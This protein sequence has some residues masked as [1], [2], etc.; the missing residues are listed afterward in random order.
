MKNRIKVFGMAAA[1]FLPFAI[2]SAVA[3]HQLDKNAR[4]DIER[5]V[6]AKV[7]ACMAA[8]ERE[9]GRHAA[10][11][12]TLG[13]AV[14]DDLNRLQKHAALVLD[15]MRPDWLNIVLARG[16]EQVFNLR[17]T[18]GREPL[19][20]T[21]DPAANARVAATRRAEID[22]VQIDH[23]RVPE[24]FIV[25]RT[26]VH[27]AGKPSPYVLIG[28]VRAW[29]FTEVLRKCGALDPEWRLGLT[30]QYGRIVGRNSAQDPRDSF[31]GQSVSASVLDG[32]S[33]GRRFFFASS[34]DGMRFYIGV[35]RSERYGWSVNLGVP[36]HVM[37]ATLDRQKNGGL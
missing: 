27:Q 29:A 1:V 11:N 10:V 3:I 2:L 23:S 7:D 31:I 4:Q 12:Q 20:P 37:D 14:D 5:T 35:A 33:R 19:A 16:A 24:P 17:L 28:V 15:E 34:R 6:V 30:D 26:P 8:V 22:G 25:V 36:S 21:R 13:T 9:I 18:N 32:L